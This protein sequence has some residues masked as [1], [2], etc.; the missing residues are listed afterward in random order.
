[1]PAMMQKES[2]FFAVKAAHLGGEIGVIK[3]KKKAGYKV[4]PIT[5]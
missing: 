5:N 4:Q 2:V 3:K 1:M